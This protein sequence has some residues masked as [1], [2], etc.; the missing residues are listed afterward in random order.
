MGAALE[1]G[2]RP[3]RSS[4]RRACAPPPPVTAG[5]PRD[6]PRLLGPPSPVVLRGLRRSHGSQRGAVLTIARPPETPLPQRSTSLTCTRSRDLVGGYWLKST[7]VFH[8]KTFAD[9]D[10]CYSTVFISGLPLDHDAVCASPGVAEQGALH[11]R[12]LRPRSHLHHRHD[13]RDGASRD[14]E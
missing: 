3:V 11:Q 6:M 4:A 5:V 13:H 14:R 2:V 12:W 8:R 9:G 10:T 1:K 7:F